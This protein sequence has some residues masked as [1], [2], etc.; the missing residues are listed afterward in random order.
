MIA[1]SRTL[2]PP[3]ALRENFFLPLM[4]SGG[5]RS[6]L[7]YG[8]ITP[9]S[10]STFTWSFSMGLGLPIFLSVMMLRE[11]FSLHIAPP[12]IMQDIFISRSLII[13]TKSLYPN[14]VI[15]IASRMNMS[16]KGPPF[17]P[18]QIC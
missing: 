18:L 15:V 4:G 17:N 7:A 1:I 2:F 13:S 10:A 12:R 14:K 16:F 6:S 11:C 8:Y 3:K 9:I 5:S